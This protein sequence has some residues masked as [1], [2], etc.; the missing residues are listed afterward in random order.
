MFS[1][2]KYYR[3]VT[4]IFFRSL[5][6]CIDLPTWPSGQRTRP[7]CAVVRDALSG[8]GSRLSSGA[9]AY[10]RIISN[11][12]YAHDEHRVNP[13]QVRGFNGVLYKL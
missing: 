11:N 13:G 1:Y 4:V 3:I 7:P 12:S 6:S 10:Q 9:S 5:S 2:Q 8:P